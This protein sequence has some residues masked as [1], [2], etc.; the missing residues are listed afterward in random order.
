MKKF[1]VIFILGLSLC[2]VI[3]LTTGR[4]QATQVRPESGFGQVPL[5]FI[6]NHGQ[7]NP[8]ALFYAKTPEYTLWLTRE[9]PRF[10]GAGMT[11]LGARPD[12]GVTASDPTD[13][14]VSYF[15]GRDEADWHTG[16]TT[17]K[18]VLYKGLYEGIDLKL[19]GTGRVVEYDW[20]V[21]AGADPTRIRFAYTEG[22]ET[23]LNGDGDLMV[24]TDGGEVKHRK[25]TAYQVI[26]GRKV[27][28]AADFLPTGG[29]AYGFDL[30]PYD[31]NFDLIIDPLVL[32]FSSYLGG[33]TYDAAVSVAVDPTGAV[34]VSGFTD[35]IDF[36]PKKVNF[37]RMDVFITKFSADGKDLIF[38]AFFPGGYWMSPFIFSQNDGVLP[39]SN[40]GGRRYAD[41]RFAV[42]IRGEGGGSGQL[43]VD[44]SG[45]A[46]LVGSTSSN[47]FPVKNAY[48]DAYGGGWQ[49]GFFLKLAPNGKS[50][51]FSSYYGGLGEESIKAAALDSKGDIYLGGEIGA[52]MILNR[53]R[54][55]G[56]LF[57]NGDIFIA[58]FQ[59]DGK[60]AVY[61]KKFGLSGL[62]LISDLALDSTGAVYAV[63]TTSSLTFPVKHAIQKKYG[64]GWMDAFILKLSPAGDSLVYSS[65]LGGLNM[66]GAT[67][68]AVDGEGAAYVTGYTW[69]EFPV[70]N[71]LRNTRR[72]GI[73]IF[74]SKI[75]P[76][77]T[78]FVYSTYWGG[79]GWDTPYDIAVDG[80]GRAY[81]AGETYSGYFTVKDAY[82]SVRTGTTDGFLTVFT[83][84]GK[85]LVLSTFFGGSYS[86][87]ISGLAID[88]K[89][90][91][92]LAGQ[93]N[94]LD[95]PLLN[96]YQAGYAGGYWDGFV[97][98]LTK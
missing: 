75:A 23:R 14:T 64:G 15:D 70:K 38:S 3:V 74:L 63:G 11:F 96:P 20:I 60:K 83:P 51:V 8:E 61:L 10:D 17:S 50:L 54:S 44:A 32:V 86:D 34:Y 42:I 94:S 6:A 41:S 35:S 12:A 31:R 43:K 9:G 76:D 65:Y 68:L 66:D 47:K 91:I 85:G 93:T 30:G 1:A 27:E 56:A 88:G 55:Q 72:G 19:Y 79:E 46:V 89:G 29:G 37:P 59:P 5:Y 80:E 77:G 92:Y 21:K 16:I 24:R 97:T 52:G 36:P 82:K 62:N 13:Y 7:A 4:G 2:T 22:S 98:K 40:P 57:G 69:G 49:D 71:A 73:D 67:A 28:V 58:K 45:A 48:Q 78:D 39:M 26:Q 84:T 81:L 95:L 87:F 18:A 25:P 90:G 53:P 33:R